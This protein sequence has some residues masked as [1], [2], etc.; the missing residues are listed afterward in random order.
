M[1]ALIRIKLD[2]SKL[3]DSAIFRG[4]KGDYADLCIV[5]NRDGTD[6]YGND[7]FI[8]QD[9]PKERREAGEK[10]PI[11][12]NWKYI[13]KKRDNPPPPPRREQPRRDPDLDPPKE[14]ENL[15]F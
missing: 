12:G 8:S 1:P 13:S 15:P 4:K 10:G 7:G 6:Q 14:R 2:L 5:E 11:V 9:V 3:D